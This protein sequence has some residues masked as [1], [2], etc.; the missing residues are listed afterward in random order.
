M[1]TLFYNIFAIVVSLFLIFSFVS[2]LREKKNKRDIILTGVHAVLF[3]FV[4][5][6][7]FFI[8]DKLSYIIVIVLLVLCVTYAA[9][10]IVMKKNKKNKK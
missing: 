8:P 2:L 3:L 7:G 6:Y 4:G 5:I 9:P 10:Y 1:E